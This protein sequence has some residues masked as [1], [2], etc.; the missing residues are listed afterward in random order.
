MSRIGGL[1]RS[2]L[3]RARAHPWSNA[4]ARRELAIDRSTR[5]PVDPSSR[6]H[7]DEALA[8]LT[9]AQNAN[10]D[11]G[12]ARGYSV[13]WNPWFGRG[14]QPSYPETT[15]YIIPTLLEAAIE[16]DRPDL[17]ERA[18]RAAHWECD[19][20]LDEGAVQGGVIGQGRTPAVFNTGQVMLGWL[21][22]HERTGEPRFADA[23]RRAGQWLVTV[24]ESD[25]I[26]R[27]G[28]SRFALAEPTLYNA[29]VA[30]A[31]AEV[32]LALGEPAFVEGANR[33]LRVVAE[34]VRPN[35]WIPA[36]C[37]TDPTQPLLHTLAYAVR[38]LIEGGRAL[39][40][41]AI[42]DV[43]L[44]AAAALRGLVRADGW[45]SGRFD[46]EWR[47]AVPWSCLTGQAQ[48]ANIWMRLFLLT[49]DA[50]WLEPVPAV[51][52]FVEATQSRTAS[53][54]G[55]RG[56]IK[57]AWPFDGEYGRFEVLNWATKYFVD[58]VLRHEQ[59]R[60][61]RAAARAHPYRLA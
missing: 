54:P 17:E 42:L 59:I 13:G 1:A 58:A 57:G 23:A 35:G 18:V 61:G 47:A 3:N 34:N 51:L 39:D 31:L 26:W 48:M 50:A 11:G 5:H 28:N 4:A 56:G 22:A 24:Q 14:W 45:M 32:G 8:W 37:L 60:S 46:A 38:G 12:F 19:V 29:R 44:R 52:A 41:G 55:L 25:G 40:D 6:P 7:L 33:N 16:L 49:G 20:Q 10:G 27:K 21:A 53:D 30:W 2:V 43:G 9:R 15:G 36:C